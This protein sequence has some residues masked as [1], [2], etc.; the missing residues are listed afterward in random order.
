MIKIMETTY[1]GDNTCDITSDIDEAF[2][3]DFNPTIKNVPVDDGG[4]CQGKFKVT[5]TWEPDEI[6]DNLEE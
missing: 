5:I 3:A 2:D 4:I 1:W 6:Y